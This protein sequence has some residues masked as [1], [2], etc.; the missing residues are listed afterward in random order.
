M[1]INMADFRLFDAEHTSS[2][3]LNLAY[4]AVK[5]TDAESAE[6]FL[7]NLRY[8]TVVDCRPTTQAEELLAVARKAGIDA[9]TFLRHICDGSA[10]GS[11]KQ[12]LRVI[13]H[14]VAVSSL[15]IVTGQAAAEGGNTGLLGLLLFRLH[16]I[17]LLGSIPQ[18]S[19]CNYGRENKRVQLRKVRRRSSAKT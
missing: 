18:R 8:A 14:R 19:K 2:L 5:L 4:H 13:C 3:P 6:R 11:L 17:L 16:L 1:P 7:Y 15:S 10:Q 9:D 12:D